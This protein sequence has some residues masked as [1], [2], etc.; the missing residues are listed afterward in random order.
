MIFFLARY[1]FKHWILNE[2]SIVPRRFTILVPYIWKSI[3]CWWLN[4]ESHA[5]TISS[6]WGGRTYLLGQL[7]LGGG[8]RDKRKL[9]KFLTGKCYTAMQE[10]TNVVC[11]KPFSS[12]LHILIEFPLCAEK[13]CSMHWGYSYEQNRK[14]FYLHSGE[15]RWKQLTNKKYK[16][17][18]HNILE[19]HKCSEEI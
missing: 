1:D 11:Y 7:T 8:T 14:I 18:T 6:L 9:T 13:L 16:W 12:I 10:L 3:L 17:L 4:K 5:L 2:F 15:A 19:S